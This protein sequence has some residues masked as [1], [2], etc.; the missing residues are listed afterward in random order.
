MK[1]D[2]KNKK[3]KRQEDNKTEISLDH[4]KRGRQKDRKIK[5]DKQD[6]EDIQ[7]ISSELF[8]KIVG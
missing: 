7:T 2:K 4:K 3:T 8:R 1:R 5:D 6:S